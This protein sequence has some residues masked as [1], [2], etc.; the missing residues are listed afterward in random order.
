MNHRP[1]LLLC[2]A[3]LLLVAGC[4]KNPAC[5]IPLPEFAEYAGEYLEVSDVLRIGHALDRTAPRVPVQ[6]ENGDTGYQYSMMI[7]SSDSARGETVSRFTVLAIEPSGD[8]EVLALLG[9]SSRP[10]EWNIVAEAPAS[11][12][13]KAARMTLAATPVPDASLR[14]DHFDGFEVE[15]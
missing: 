10:G 2:C 3:A 15:R 8:A 13:G 5:I 1:V 7:F 12:V 9:R 14:S 6:W 4:K 11:P